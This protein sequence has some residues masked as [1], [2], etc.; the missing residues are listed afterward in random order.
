LTSCAGRSASR[1]RVNAFTTRAS[2]FLARGVCEEGWIAL[3]LG[4]A[5]VPQS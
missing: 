3:D 5:R 4:L 1:T 2:I